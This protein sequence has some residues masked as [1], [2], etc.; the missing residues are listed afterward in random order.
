MSRVTSKDGT[1]IAYDRQGIGPAVILVTGALDDGSENAPLAT[2]L[3]QEFTVT[4]M[5]GEA[6]ATAE[7]P[8]GTPW[9]ARSRTSRRSSPRPGDRHTSTASRRAACLR[10]HS[11]LQS[12][13]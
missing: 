6:E 13:R 10:V 8:C 3:A 5:P 9:I 2:E 7:T 4:T 11:V 12:P 1:S